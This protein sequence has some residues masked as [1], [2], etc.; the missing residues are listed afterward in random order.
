MTTGLM[1]EINATDIRMAGTSKKAYQ[2]ATR[3]GTTGLEPAAS[4]VTE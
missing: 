4:A 1:R 3:S 2:A